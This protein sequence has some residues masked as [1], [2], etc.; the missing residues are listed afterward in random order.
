[1]PA[2]SAILRAAL[3]LLFVRS[4][5]A[6]PVRF[7]PPSSGPA[8]Q[9]A[10]PTENDS[11][12][13]D[14]PLSNRTGES[15]E[16]ALERFGGNRQTEQA[17]ADGL[18]WLAAHQRPDGMWDR[19]HF[20]RRCPRA[21]PCPGFARDRLGHDLNIG[22]S[23]LATLAF[24]G[25]GYTHEDGLYAR[26]VTRA[27]EYILAQQT[28]D[29]T[30][31]PDS[32]VQMYNDAVATLAVAEAYLATNDPI[33]ETPLR[34]AVAHLAR[35]QQRGG[36]WDY[37]ARQTGRN[38]T[39]ITG[40]V[41]MAIK[42]AQAAGVSAPP[43]TVWRMIDHFKNAS[44]RDGRV[45]YSDQ[46]V[47]VEEGGGRRAQRYGPAMTAV[48]LFGHTLIGWRPDDEIALKQLDVIMSDPPSHERMTKTDKSGLHSEYYWYYGTLALFHRGGDEWAVWNRHLR[49]TILEYQDRTL[50]ADGGRR[51]TY[52]SWRPYGANWGLWGKM[53]GR[54]Y[55]TAINTL[56][57][58]IY[59]RYVPGYLS[60][61]GLIGPVELSTFVNNIAADDRASQIP[62]L[63]RFHRDTAEPVLLEMLGTGVPAARLEAALALAELGSPMARDEL[64]RRAGSA[65]ERARPRIAK[66][67]HGINAES[68]PGLQLGQ[69]K[70]VSVAAGMLLFD[71]RG[72]PVYYGQ[73][74]RIL[75]NG[76]VIASGTIDRRFSAHDAAVA[77]FRDGAPKAG[78]RVELAP[79]APATSPS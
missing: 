40:W 62:R 6:M 56:T 22:V 57:L 1:V 18:A 15:R 34:R 48:G 69:V 43:E 38:D 67:L 26:T 32:T 46:G 37:S 65:D 49:S 29:G 50:D 25:A 54:I 42:S 73:A 16:R 2:P 68:A 19:E 44:L 55:T 76:Q 66:A 13:N 20:E 8:S 53:G 79:L 11:E 78:D 33:F 31:S 64:N 72:K 75:R 9:P 71:T 51:H 7:E 28:V 70:R 3:L 61:H 10:R 77:S 5:A 23:G 60:S 17:V 41:L 36:G 47:G 39:S 58:E 63:V 30:F 14:R 59:Y 52:G 74:V 4:A 12:P 27:F 21:D 24:L 45:W 35:S